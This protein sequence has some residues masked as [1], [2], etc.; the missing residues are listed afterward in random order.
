MITKPNF[1]KSIFLLL[2]TIILG[3]TTNAQTYD[4]TVAK[5][6]SG[7]FKTVQAAIDSAPTGRTAAFKIYIKNGKYKEKITIPSNK[8]FI[9]LIGESVAN[10]ILTYD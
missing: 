5:D 8:P 4:F 7:N 6:G 1:L 10:T 3:F 2:A 9:Q